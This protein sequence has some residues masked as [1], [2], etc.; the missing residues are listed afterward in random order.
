MLVA[1]R[2]AGLRALK[3]HYAGVNALTQCGAR[4]Y[5]LAAS[6]AADATIF[7]PTVEAAAAGPLMF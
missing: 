3:R 5:G 7:G 2:L 6:R 1:Y 4:Q